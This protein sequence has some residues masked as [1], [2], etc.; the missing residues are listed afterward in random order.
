MAG[1]SSTPHAV[2]QEISID[3]LFHR[4]SWLRLSCL[5]HGGGDSELLQILSERSSMVYL[6]SGLDSFLLS[7]VST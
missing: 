4:K 6:E 3:F 2:Q 7:N 1:A 5:P